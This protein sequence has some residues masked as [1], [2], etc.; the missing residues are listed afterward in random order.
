MAA[1]R[2]VQATWVEETGV[3]APGGPSSLRS[4]GMTGGR[5]GCVQGG[6]V[7]VKVRVEVA[8]SL[9]LRHSEHGRGIFALTGQS[10]D[11]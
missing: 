9:T 11:L 2:L 3:A 8:A 7:V 1:S 6:V 10:I 4:L 5:W